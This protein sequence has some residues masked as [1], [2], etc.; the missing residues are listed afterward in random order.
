[1]ADGG[2]INEFSII[3]G[4][5]FND[6][7]LLR[8][9]LTHTSFLNE[10]KN[11]GNC[12]ERLEFLGDS[13]LELL[14]TD[15]LFSRYDSRSEGDMSEFRKHIV[16]EDSLAGV[17]KKLNVGKYL[18]LGNGEEITGGREKKSILSDALEAIIAAVYIDSNKSISIVSGVFLP[19][20]SD[21]LDKCTKSMGGDYKSQ[22]KKLVEKDGMEELSYVVAEQRK[23][24]DN[25]NIFVV[26]AMLNSNVIGVGV[27]RKIKDAENQAARQALILFGFYDE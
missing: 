23:N 13:V 6:S 5:S 18:F 4:Y 1:M 14:V 10:N 8:S 2:N 22:L 20:F 26:N 9:A 7:E 17:A 15:Y 21:V 11:T 3:L 25:T 19:F 24:K 27:G 16:C 12:Y